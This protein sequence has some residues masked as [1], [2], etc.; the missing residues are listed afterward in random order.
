MY[1]YCCPICRQRGFLLRA[2]YTPELLDRCWLND[3]HEVPLNC[4]S[5]NFLVPYLTVRRA[6]ND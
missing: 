1:L 4:V 5:V 2:D 3:R 6:C